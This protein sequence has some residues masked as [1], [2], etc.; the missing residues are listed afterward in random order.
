MI[1]SLRQRHTYRHTETPAPGAPLRGAATVRLGG[2]EPTGPDVGRQP[3]ILHTHPHTHTIT[4]THT[5]P[6]TH[7]QAR[8]SGHKRADSPPT[9]Y[10]WPKWPTKNKSEKKHATFIDASRCVC[11]V[12]MYT[13]TCFCPYEYMLSVITCCLYDL[14]RLKTFCLFSN[15]RRL[16]PVKFTEAYQRWLPQFPSPSLPPTPQSS[17]TLANNDK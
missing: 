10:C 11:K 13:R 6:H 15:A 16:W 9:V 3:D 4:H 5:H 17:S 7:T 8:L 12:E 1:A 14:C 2:R